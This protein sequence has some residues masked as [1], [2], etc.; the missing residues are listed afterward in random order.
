MVVVVVV[1]VIVSGPALVS[2]VG[3]EHIPRVHTP[4]TTLLHG[5]PSATGRL[6]LHELSDRQTG[7]VWQSSLEGS[8][9][10]VP[11]ACEGQLAKQQYALPGVGGSYLHPPSPVLE[12]H[13]GLPGPPPS[14]EQPKGVAG[15]SLLL[16]TALQFLSH[17]SPEYPSSHSHLHVAAANSV[18]A[19]TTQEP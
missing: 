18:L 4:P 3:F 13:A 16:Q 11:V 9:S 10:Q 14:G 19:T 8:Q 7:G 6:A 2:C 5:V 15:L 17:A 1:V 12:H